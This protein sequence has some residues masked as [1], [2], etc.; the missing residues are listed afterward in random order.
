MHPGAGHV[1]GR[2]SSAGALQ[3]TGAGH[4]GSGT[5][6]GL[7]ERSRALRRSTWMPSGPATLNRTAARKFHGGDGGA[8]R[9]QV[10][11]AGTV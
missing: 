8:C 1:F 4:T 6:R 5:E 10:P 9:D 2:P 11:R 7:T 3:R